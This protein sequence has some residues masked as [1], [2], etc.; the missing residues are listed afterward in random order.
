MKRYNFYNRIVF[1]TALISA[2]SL[3]SCS[4]SW[5]EPKPLSI[6]TPEN[7][8]IDAAGFYSALTTCERNMRHE[9]TKDGAPILTEFFFSEMAVEGTTDGYGCVDASGCSVE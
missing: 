5:L 4:D 6:Y 2:L 8:Y 1:P 3:G 7:S 9:F